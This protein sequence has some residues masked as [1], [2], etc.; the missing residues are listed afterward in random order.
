MHPGCLNPAIEVRCERATRA[1]IQRLKFDIDYM[2][3]PMMCDL[4]GLSSIPYIYTALFHRTR[5]FAATVQS[6]IKAAPTKWTEAAC[7]L[8]AWSAD[9]LRHPDIGI[10]RFLHS[11]RESL[12]WILDDALLRILMDQWDP[13]QPLPQSSPIS[14]GPS[15]KVTAWDV[16]ITPVRLAL[17]KAQEN[18]SEWSERDLGEMQKGVCAWKGVQKELLVQG[19]FKRSRTLC[20]GGQLPAELANVIVEHV[21]RFEEWPMVDLR[22][23]HLPKGTPR[24]W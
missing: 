17:C 3:Y 21:A 22:G 18:L 11:Q 16:A 9:I 15:P 14:T 12:Y 5:E 1:S 2:N 23:W 7:L 8:V 4:Q 24:T 19:W 20:A 10:E 6:L 13:P